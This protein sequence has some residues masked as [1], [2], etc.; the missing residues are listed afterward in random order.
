MFALPRSSFSGWEGT[1][2]A[3]DIQQDSDTQE[4]T[5]SNRGNEHGRNGQH[6]ERRKQ[7]GSKGCSTEVV[8]CE[9]GGWGKNDECCNDGDALRG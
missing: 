8:L 6:L 2:D 1:T 9:C 3:A 5:D 4:L 7:N